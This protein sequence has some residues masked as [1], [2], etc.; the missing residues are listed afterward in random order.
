M[1]DHS[2]QPPSVRE[3][4]AELPDGCRQKSTLKGVSLVAVTLAAYLAT[5]VGAASSG[6]LWVAVPAS[7][8][9]GLSIAALFVL[10]HDACHLSLT[11]KSALNKIMG[12]LVFLPSLQP[13]T[14]WEHTHNGLH[15]AWT[16]V[17]GKD[18]AYAPFSKPQFDALPFHR[19]L[20]ERVY[21]TLPGMCLLHLVEIWLKTE[22]LPTGSK[23]PKGRQLRFHLDRLLVFGFVAT[24]LLLLTWWGH[25]EPTRTVVLGFV[26]PILVWHWFA[27]LF[28]FLQHT[29]PRVPWYSSE[30]DYTFYA[31][32]VRSAVHVELPRRFEQLFHNVMQH[33]A[34]HV[35]PKIPLYNLVDSQKHLEDTYVNEIT[36]VRLNVKNA[37]WTMRTCKL[38]DYKNHQWLSFS[39]K[40]L[41][42]PLI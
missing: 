5:L 38:F 7:I 36:T 16:N 32:Q 25:Y 11:P 3:V 15:H 41:T 6:S 13:F 35:D 30:D 34:H 26:L 21:R 4:R 8:L 28:T 23:K 37:L 9:N 22:M 33:T 17:Q 14:S 31:G 40:P 24:E 12:R 2:L 39:G 1:G 10:G 19:R 29:H 42:E 20:L 27:G 18:P